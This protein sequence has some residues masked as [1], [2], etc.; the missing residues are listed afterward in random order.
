MHLVD[1]F[2]N[3]GRVENYLDN[4]FTLI[5]LFCIDDNFDT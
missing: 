5:Y 2:N 4:I 3:I 1:N